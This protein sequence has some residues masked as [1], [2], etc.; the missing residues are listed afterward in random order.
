MYRNYPLYIRIVLSFTG[1]LDEQNEA[2]A[3]ETMQ[4]DI[5]LS[6]YTETRVL[7]LLRG[8]LGGAVP[9]YV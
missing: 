2:T 7:N 1:R 3:N 6:F 5:H 4:S 8:S 9:A